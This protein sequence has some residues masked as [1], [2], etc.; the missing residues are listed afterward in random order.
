MDKLM[1]RKKGN[2][3]DSIPEKVPAGHGGN[4]RRLGLNIGS[5]CVKAVMLGASGVE[6]VEVIPHEGDVPGTLSRLLDAHQVPEG[7]MSLV[8]GPEGRRQ[9][10]LPGIIEPMALEKALGLIG[11]GFRAVVAVGGEDLVVY[12]LDE[13]GRVART[14]AGNKCASGTGEFFSQQLKR[15]DLGLDAVF[16][17][18]TDKATACRLSSRCSVFMKSDCTHKL[19]KGEVSR[20]DVVLALSNVMAKKITEFLSRARI[21]EGRVLLSGGPTR[22]PHLIRFIREALPGVEFV[23]PPEAPHLEAFGAAHLAGELG[24]PLPTRGELFAPGMVAFGRAKALT[25]ASDKVEFVTH[26]RGSFRKG[27]T[28]V[29]GVDGGSTTTKV[30]LMDMDDNSI[31]A[32][33]YGRTLG[34]PVSALKNCLGEVKKQAEAALGKGEPVRIRLV[35]TTG[36]SREL[37]GVFCGTRGVYNEILAH[38][39]GTTYFDPEIDT[40]FEIGGQDAKYVSLRNHVPVDYAMNEACSAGTG[41]FLEEAAAGDLDIRRAED[42]GP[43]A[44]EAKAPLKFGEHCSAFINSDIRKAIGQGASRPDI[45]AG[46]VMSIVANYLNRVVGNRRIGSH[47]VLQGGVAKNPAVPLA[48]AALLGKEIIVPPDPELL[49]SFGVGLLALR[50][51]REGILEESEYSLDGLMGREIVYEREYTCQACENLCPIRILRVGEERYHFGGRC[52]KYANL[53]KKIAIDE[54]ETV[55]WTEVRRRMYFEKFAPAPGTLVKRTDKIVGIPETFGVH[56]LYPLYSTFFHG[57]GV[58][59]LLVSDFNEKDMARCESSFCFP[60]EAAH[61]MMG[62]LLRT[63]ADYYFLPHFKR[64]ESLEDDVHACT[65]PFTQGQPYYLRT[66]F[67]VDDAKILRPVLDFDKGFLKGG[68]PMLEVAATLGFS[69]ADAV[70]AWKAAVERQE[71]CFAEGRAIGKR[72]MEEARGKSRPVIVLFGRPYNAFAP[73]LNMS[74]PRK[75]STRG[76]SVLPFDFLPVGN[77]EILPNMYWY[78]G[79]LDMKGAVQVKGHPDLFPCFITNFSCAPDS[80]MLHYLRWIN[81]SKPFLVLELDSHTAD[82]GIDTRVEAFLDIVEGYRRGKPAESP[83]MVERDWDLR[84]DGGKSGAVHRRTGEFRDMRHKRLK[85]LWPSMGSCSTEFMSQISRHYGIDS[86]AL[87]VPAMGTAARARAVA[88]GKECIPTLLVLGSMLDYFSRNQLDPDTVYMVFTPSTTGPCR[89][90]QY[91]VFYQSLFQELGYSNVLVLNLSSDNSYTELGKEFSKLSWVAMTLGDALQDMEYNLRTLAVDPVSA[92]AE[93]R[94]ILAEIVA[95]MGQDPWG[96]MKALPGWAGR[97]SRIPLKKTIK[98]SRKVMVVGEIYVRRDDYSVGTLMSHLS[99]NGIV[100]KI[101]GLGEW[102]DY[103]DFDQVYRYGK[104]VKAMPIWR[105][106]FS[107]EFRK[108]LSLKVEIRWKD[109]MERRIMG[110]LEPSGLVIEGP[111][112][113]KKI[114]RRAPGFTSLEFDT[115]ATLSTC[116]ATTAMDDGFHGIAV[117]APFACLPGRLVESLYGPWARA[118]NHPVICLENDGNPYPPN[119]VNRIEIFIHNVKRPAGSAM[120]AGIPAG[121]ASAN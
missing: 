113:M 96:V 2:A 60:A 34:D 20:F 119:V 3:S 47:I 71:A 102:I 63:N 94:I 89:V 117:I 66:A 59:T 19:N 16:K 64:M 95:M 15:M 100:G 28:Y 78:Y 52:N 30:V 53:R 82:A 40:I 32:A 44:M 65:C 13:E 33:H 121:K 14:Y 56:T 36:S 85:L 72:V 10:R 101:E 9:V 76:Y 1:G 5:T 93:F 8:T 61:G 97:L 41:S 80:F 112:D 11:S 4:N 17:P 35:A 12:A 43:V 27:A 62:S 6:W 75:F 57:L 51:L 22:N 81:N 114:M 74:I 120:L 24:A 45:V 98:E 58:E 29:L 115:E 26:D 23:L 110:A 49:G 18:E 105:R 69:R 55:D 91:A 73:G 86:V 83:M 25:E 104:K 50:K 67:R 48:F 116:T 118:R 88:S 31:V 46:L 77:E 54:K 106:Y 109:W 70:R 99:A 68:E 37:L 111:T 90:G 107:R 108:L 38:T 84:L 103:L 42:I 87:P 92:G 79:Q 39:V 21:E 7:V